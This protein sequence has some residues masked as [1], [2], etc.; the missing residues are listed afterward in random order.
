MT[1]H[2][3]GSQPDEDENEVFPCCLA[4]KFLIEYP[5]EVTGGR[6]KFFRRVLRPCTGSW[7]LTKMETGLVSLPGCMQGAGLQVPRACSDG[8]DDR[9]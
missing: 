4:G 2:G 8:R 7:T 9:Q 6:V 3:A 1:F 5:S